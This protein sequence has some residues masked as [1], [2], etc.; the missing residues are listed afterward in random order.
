MIFTSSSVD[1]AMVLH[2][3]TMCAFA[4]HENYDHDSMQSHFHLLADVTC[5]CFCVRVCDT[6]Q[7][8]YATT[9]HG[10]TTRQ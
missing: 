1:L 8:A 3:D 10:Y 4:Y 7:R 5:V 9:R 6:T 2:D